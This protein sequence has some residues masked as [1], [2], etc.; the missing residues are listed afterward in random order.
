VGKVGLER[1]KKRALEA[2]QAKEEKK[3]L[4]AST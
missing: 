3:R 2:M 4:K 1:Q